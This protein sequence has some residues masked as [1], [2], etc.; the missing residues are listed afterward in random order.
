MRVRE[1]VESIERATDIEQL[2]AGKK[3]YAKVPGKFGGSHDITIGITEVGGWELFQIPV[4]GMDG[5]ERV[6]EMLSP[7]LEYAS[8]RYIFLML[9]RIS[10]VGLVL[11]CI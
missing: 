4:S 9:E 7:K 6:Q 3:D 5:V 11:V 10:T 1:D 2:K 8:T